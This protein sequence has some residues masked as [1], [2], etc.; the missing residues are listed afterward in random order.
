MAEIGQLGLGAGDDGMDAI[1]QIIGCA[2]SYLN[3][4]GVLVVEAGHNRALVEEAFPALPFTW[5]DTP[6]AAEMVFV[7]RRDELPV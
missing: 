1:R 7:L 2:R 3:L 6:S 5:L 4:G